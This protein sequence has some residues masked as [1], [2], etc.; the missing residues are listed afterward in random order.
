[1]FHHLR[2]LKTN[3][4]FPKST[5]KKGRKGSGSSRISSR[6]LG[7]SAKIEASLSTNLGRILRGT[8]EASFFAESINFKRRTLRGVTYS[9]VRKSR[10]Q[11]ETTNAYESNDSKI[12]EIIPLLS[13]SVG[14]NSENWVFYRT[15]TDLGS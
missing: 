13:R 5:Q 12:V 15:Q 11:R 6:R 8:F 14:P 9:L 2:S 3:I 1:M 4:E 7:V 10:K